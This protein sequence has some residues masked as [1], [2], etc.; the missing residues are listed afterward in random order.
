M[1]WWSTL[2]TVFTKPLRGHW[3]RP[4]WIGRE[5]FLKRAHATLAPPWQYK[6]VA[7][8]GLAS[9]AT[10]FAS[11]FTGL[12]S[13]WSLM[14]NGIASA[15]LVSFG[16]FCLAIRP[17]PCLFATYTYALD[18]RIGGWVGKVWSCG[19]AFF[20]ASGAKIQWQFLTA[21]YR[22]NSS[23]VCRWPASLCRVWLLTRQ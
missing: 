19:P 21:R 4:P 23:S 10:N 16:C 7:C 15:A 18:L 11:F 20:D 13:F 9:G 5:S 17:H 8:L 6:F 22:R 1:S 12:S 2:L 14:K 3:I